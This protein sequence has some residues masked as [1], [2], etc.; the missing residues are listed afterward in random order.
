IDGAILPPSV[1]LPGKSTDKNKSDDRMA[2]FCRLRIMNIGLLF[3]FIGLRI[4]QGHDPG[5]ELAITFEH[6]KGGVFTLPE[7]N[8]RCIVRCLNSSRSETAGDQCPE[9][10]V[11]SPG[12]HINVSRSF[13][14]VY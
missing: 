11:K 1:T 14:Q 8:G 5:A 13:P 7:S 4:A 6:L 9:Q 10:K 12:F 2:S 3:A